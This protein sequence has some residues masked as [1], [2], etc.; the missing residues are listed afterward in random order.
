MPLTVPGG[1]KVPLGGGPA[2]VLTSSTARP[3]RRFSSL[4]SGACAPAATPGTT[5]SAGKSRGT[6]Q[7]GGFRT[8]RTPPPAVCWVIATTSVP[9]A[10][11]SRHVL[12]RL[13]PASDG[14][15]VPV[16]TCCA[17][18]WTPEEADGP[19]RHVAPGRDAA[20]WGLIAA[21]LTFVAGGCAPTS[22]ARTGGPELEVGELVRDGCGVR[23]GRCCPVFWPARRARRLVPRDRR[24]GAPT[25]SV[26]YERFLSRQGWPSAMAPPRRARRLT[27]PVMAGVLAALRAVGAA[28]EA[29]AHPSPPA[30]CS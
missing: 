25:V 30:R 17:V 3:T 10:T 13:S 5:A 14:T 24:N 6:H 21:G 23:D 19:P 12:S 28:A 29:L 7:V 26:Q 4:S 1:S 16:G 27:A 22:R 20:V 9:A 18:R 11:A 2:Y 15:S 8:W